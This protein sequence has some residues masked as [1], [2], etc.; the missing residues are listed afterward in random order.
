[1]K[2]L[3]VEH[4]AHVSGQLGTTGETSAQVGAGEGTIQVKHCTGRSTV[5]HC[6]YR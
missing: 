3:Q 6:T 1:M 4:C 2:A 5:R